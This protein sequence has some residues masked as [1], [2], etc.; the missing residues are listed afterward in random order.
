MNNTQILIVEDEAVIATDLQMALMTM[1]YSVAGMASSGEGA[2]EKA[3]AERPD[4]VLMDIRLNGG[5][6]GIDAAARIRERLNIPVVYLSAYADDEI[7]ARAKMTQPYGYLLKPV[8]HKELQTTIEM[9][10][11]R[12]RAETEISERQRWLAAT[13]SCIGDG[14]IATDS[15][16]SVKF[17]NRVAEQL[18][19][20]KRKEAEGRDLSSV[21]SLVSE[22][23]GAPEE[24]E[25]LETVRRGAVLRLEDR[26]LVGRDGRHTVVEDSVAPILD[27]CGN[28]AGMVVV[29]HD[30]SEKK[31]NRELILQSAR[32]QAVSDL[33]GGVAHNFNNLLQ[34][35]VGYAQLALIDIRS[36]D[37]SQITE[38]LDTILGSC[39]AAAETVKRLQDFAR[40]R[41]DEAMTET[42]IVDVSAMVR[43]AADMNYSAQPPGSCA[44]K[45]K[46]NLDVDLDP[47][48][49]VRGNLGQLFQVAFNLIAN[50]VE[51][52]SQGGLISVR[53]FCDDDEVFL[54]VRDTG[55]GIPSKDLPN[56][57]LP[58]WTSKGP[59]RT[60]MG[61][62]SCYGIVSRHGGNIHITSREA[63]GTTATVR[64][65]RQ[66]IA[67]EQPKRNASCRPSHARLRILVIDDLEPILGLLERELSRS[68]HTVS[69]ALS[70]TEGLAIFQAAGA[71]LVICDLGM[72]DMNGWAVSEALQSFCQEK[73]C[74]KPPFILLTGWDVA[75]LRSDN[76]S[77]PGVDRSL[78]K[79]VEMALLLQ[80]IEEIFNNVEQAGESN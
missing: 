69:T 28:V 43:E 54:V 59:L 47:D 37:R 24:K 8:V 63:K 53:T 32:L 16:A 15:E 55:E 78:Q 17:M 34:I 4:L 68:G 58:F 12:H 42:S 41:S 49:M 5:I 64:L 80:T 26:T 57:F 9:A 39:R 56:V 73:G 77:R 38:S 52:T 21:F 19:G 13:L 66:R 3:E 10:L 50:A 30:A 7:L 22:Q 14:L 6:D 36:G 75:S 2:V 61:L 20:W 33:A 67:C 29:F 70:G 11:H 51:A 44:G 60:G 76:A 48:C 74:P 65:P 31:K 79:P 40:I 46:P 72:E 62:S 35:I 23:T 27:D 71:D 25:W 1:G 18:T 45:P